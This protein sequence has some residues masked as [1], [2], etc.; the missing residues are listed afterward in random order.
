MENTFYMGI[1]FKPLNGFFIKNAAKIVGKYNLQYKYSAD[2]DYFYRMIV[3]HNL[4]G[5]ATKKMNYLVFLDV[6][7]IRV[8]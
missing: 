5:V 6:V 1:L 7:D 3:K 2:Y 4:K 8:Q